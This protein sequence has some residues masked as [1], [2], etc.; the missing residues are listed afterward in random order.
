[1]SF[2]TFA[3]AAKISSWAV[4]AIEAMYKAGVLNG[5]SNGIFDPQGKASRA[6]V[7]AMLMNFMEAIV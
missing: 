4:E 7:A 2:Y 6:E 3:D 1:M 5:K